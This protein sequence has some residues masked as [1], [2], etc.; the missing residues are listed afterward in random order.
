[1]FFARIMWCWVNRRGQR[2]AKELRVKV[3]EA[4]APAVRPCLEVKF[5][6]R[7]SGV[8]SRGRKSEVGDGKEKKNH[9]IGTI[10]G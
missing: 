3:E 1:M 8:G 4:D 9:V 6:D 10:C 5:R 2:D 7:K